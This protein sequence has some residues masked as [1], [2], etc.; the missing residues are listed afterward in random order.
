[1]FSSQKSWFS[2]YSTLYLQSHDVQHAIMERYATDL[3]LSF[4]FCFIATQ[5]E[6]FDVQHKIA[7]GNILLKASFDQFFQIM[8]HYFQQMVRN[9]NY[10]FFL[11]GCVIIS[12]L[13]NTRWCSLQVDKRNNHSKSGKCHK[14]STKS[15]SLKS[16]QIVG[17]WKANIQKENLSE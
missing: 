1:M 16:R 9:K 4:G 17:I 15:Y 10:N 6:C 14:M 5:K 3:T 7:S 11:L 2:G 8:W 12:C 13:C